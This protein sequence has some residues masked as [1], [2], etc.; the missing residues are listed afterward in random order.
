MGVG[1][2]P[3]TQSNLTGLFAPR[4]VAIV[5]ATDHP[6]SFGGRL[7]Q[8]VTGFGFPGRIYPVN[9]RLRE[10]SGLK[11]HPGLKDLPETPDHVGIVV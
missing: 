10:I 1:V 2:T 9:P 7:F 3:E 11:C 5:G 4:A 8:T 6:S